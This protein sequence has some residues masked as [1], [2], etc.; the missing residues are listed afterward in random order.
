MS[1]FRRRKKEVQVVQPTE[2]KSITD[3]KLI[4]LF[5]EEEFIPLIVQHYSD[6]SQINYALFQLR[7]KEFCAKHGIAARADHVA[8][9]EALYSE[10]QH[11][12]EARESLEI[13][14]RAQAVY[15]R[16]TTE[17]VIELGL[18]SPKPR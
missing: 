1:R 14:A 17:R 13:L 12:N 2:S 3:P 10:L 7:W 9:Y 6:S 4:W 8:I 5:L 11:P 18:M 15:H 16:I